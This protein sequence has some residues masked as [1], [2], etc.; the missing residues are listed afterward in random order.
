MLVNEKKKKNFYYYYQFYY[1]ILIILLKYFFFFSLHM[2]LVKAM[3]HMGVI[4]DNKFYDGCAKF[5][6]ASVAHGTTC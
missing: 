1:L 3:H 5:L 6:N 2:I 4:L